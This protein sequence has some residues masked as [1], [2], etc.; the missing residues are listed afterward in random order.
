M[1]CM[2]LF[3]VGMNQNELYNNKTVR[4]T[5]MKNGMDRK[6]GDYNAFWEGRDYLN[7]DVKYESRTTDV[8]WI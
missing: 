2:T 5:E 1:S 4:D 3:I 8:A 7:A 6:T